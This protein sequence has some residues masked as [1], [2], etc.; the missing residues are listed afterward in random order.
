MSD[1]TFH[2]VRRTDDPDTHDATA[3]RQRLSARNLPKVLHNLEESAKYFQLD[4]EL[5]T[6]I[7]M[8]LTV[9]APLLLTGEP[10]TGKTQV[11][12]YLGWYFDIA[13]Y[14]YQVRSASTANDMKY[15][16]DAVAYLRNA[17]D[18][19][20]EVRERQ[21]FLRPKALWQAYTCETDCVLLIDEIDKA[22]RDF[23]NDLLQELANH[24][25]QHPFLDRVITPKSDKPPIVII[26]SNVERRLP[27]AFLRRCIFHHID[28]TSQLVRDAV[29]ARAGNFPHLNEDAL[30]EAL[31]RFWEIRDNEEIQKLPSTAE[32]LVWLAILSAR[33]VTANQL[34]D[35]R[36][37]ELPGLTA[38]LK[39]KGDME[40]LER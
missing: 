40:R 2:L 39:D 16:F 32:V 27:D 4:P 3:A 6:A 24:R 36:L 5:E 21:N 34:R 29:H 37:S 23:P 30:N 12:W 13:V 35:V 38:L 8:A 20:A 14:T 28:L 33:G 26:T 31:N 7:N 11:A 1:R 19:K 25:F 17:Q 22:P 9:G 15:D 18:P 10:G